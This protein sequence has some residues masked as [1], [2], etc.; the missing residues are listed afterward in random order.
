MELSDGVIEWGSVGADGGADGRQR[1][2]A[3]AWVAFGLWAGG[4]RGGCHSSRFGA[5]LSEGVS[6]D[7]GGRWAE[8][9][10]RCMV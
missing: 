5:V 3:R 10:R 4:G 7:D 2:R 6:A 1:G 8:G 9:L